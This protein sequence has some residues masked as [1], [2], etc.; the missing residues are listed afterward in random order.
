MR[1]VSVSGR[2]GL[3]ASLESV[4][5]EQCPPGTMGALVEAACR[6]AFAVPPAWRGRLGPPG[7]ALWRQCVPD[8][9]ELESPAGAASPDPLDETRHAVLPGAIQRYPDRLLVLL[10]DRCAG[11]CRFCTRRRMVGRSASPAIAGQETVPPDAVAVPAERGAVTGWLRSHPEVRDVLLSGGDPLMLPDDEIVAWV[12]EVRAVRPGMLIRIGTR[13]PSFAPERITDAL[14]RRLAEHGPVYVNVHFNHTDELTDEARSACL[15]MS[16]LGLIAGN[17]TVLLAGV[18]DSVSQLREL[19][20]GL[21]SCGVRPYYLHTMDQVEG[22]AH[23]R[24]PLARAAAIWE[25]LA[26]TTSGMAVP[27]MMIDLP[28]GGGKIQYM[29]GM[30]V[31]D[32]G[33]GQLVFRNV[34]G[35]LSQYGDAGA[36]AP[37]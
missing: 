30:L 31:E 8:V 1:G 10:S 9:R 29:R 15:R 20:F 12:R 25:E 18:N 11:Y 21:L 7:S 22:T 26:L 13:M 32:R 16:A 17:Q 23:F 14:C 33:G 2:E 6:H 5:G 27:R 28:D 19:F 37:M 24:V 34:A 36:G 4:I 35:G 3:Q